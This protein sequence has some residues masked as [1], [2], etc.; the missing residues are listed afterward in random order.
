MSTVEQ[1]TAPPVLSRTPGDA[2]GGRVVVRNLTK[3]F[4][5]I[6][7]VRDLS[8]TVEP[9][10]VTGFL[11]PNGAG[12]T[13]TLRAALGLIRPTGGE[14]TF[15]GVGYRR[16]AHPARVVGAVLDSNG[17]HRSRKARAHLRMYAAAIGMPDQRADEVLAMVGLTDA[18]NRKV[19]GFSLGMRQR[20]ALA[21]ALLGDPP[22]LILDEPGSG[23]DPEGV[24]W[25]RGFLRSYAA[26]GRTV[27]V[28]SHQ[29]AEIAQTVDRVVIISQGAGVFEGPI[30]ELPGEDRDEVRVRCSD[31][32]RLATAL[33]AR[34]IT[35]IASL[36]EGW[37]S[38]LGADT[39][40]VGDLARTVD[41][42]VYGMTR[43]HTD[44]EQRFLR[45]TVS[46]YRPAA[47]NGRPGDPPDASAEPARSDAARS[48]AVRSDTAHAVPAQAVPAQREGD[49]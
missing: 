5:S 18:A 41:V 32:G 42:A 28:S 12:K 3:R 48:D 37:L 7:A 17:F 22:V 25:L 47:P 44:L 39:T 40:T 24:A 15:D 36:P 21:T 33:S 11:G 30:E 4:G 49:R 2:M 45:L 23:L 38:V 16:L 8:F 35:E 26:T 27:L 19:G 9:G 14:V 43:E 29:L 46:Q 10:Q 6:E 13:T 34:G 1:P 20:L 31:P